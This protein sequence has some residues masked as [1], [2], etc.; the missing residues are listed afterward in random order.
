MQHD[1]GKILGGLIAT[2]LALNLFV[3]G[4]L[5]YAMLEAKSR[6][7]REVRTTVENLAL[8]LDQSVS[9]SVREIDLM[10]RGVS[11]GSSASCAKRGGCSATISIRRSSCI[12]TGCRRRPRCA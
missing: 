9:S 8:L 3:A 6:K 7:E 4:L 12:V 1:S 2:V 5:G 10:L 11:F